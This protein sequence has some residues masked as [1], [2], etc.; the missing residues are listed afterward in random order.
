MGRGRFQLI[1]IVTGLGLVLLLATVGL[2]QGRR[3]GGNAGESLPS[4]E[5]KTAGMRKIDGFLPLYW[6]EKTGRLWMEIARLGQEILHLS[7]IGAGLGS[8]DIGLDRGAGSGSE[9]IKFER[10]GPQ[11]LLIQPNYRFRASSS[12]PEEVRAVTDAFAPSVLWGFPAAAETG[13]RVLVDLTPYV[14]RD[15]EGFTGRLRPGTYR[16][17]SSRSAIY[18]PM[19]MGFP[20]NSEVEATL[21]FVSQGGGG[22]GG[23]RRGGGSFEGV[24]SVAS[25]SEAATVRVHHGFVELPDDD[26]T[27]RLFDS[28]SGFSATTYADYSAPLGDDMVKRFVSRHRLKKKDPRAAVSEA[29]E[30]II[31]Y[32]DPGTPEP[33]RSALLE[34]ARWWNQ[35]FE[36]AGYSE[37]FQVE[38][39]P[40]HISSH[41]IRYNVI[42]WVHRSTRG[43][44]TGGSVRDPRTGEII[45]GI[46]TLGSLRVRQDYMIAEGLLSP[47]RNGDETPPELAAWALARIRQLSAHEVGHTLGLGHNYYDS[48]TGRISVLD[49]PHPLVT[50]KPDGSLD[51]SEVY[52]VGIGEWDKISITYGYTDFAPGTDEK[53]ELAKILNDAWARDIRYM[54]NQDTNVSPRTDQ[55]SNGTN[56]AVELNRMLDVRRNALGRFGVNAIKTGRPMATLEEVLVPLYLHHRYQVEAAASVLGGVHYIYAFRGDNRTPFK[57]ASGSEQRAAMDALLRTLEPS[58]LA[59]PNSILD[60]IPPRPGGY[61]GSRELFPKMTGGMFDTLSPAIVAAS[62]TVFQLLNPARAARIVQQHAIDPALPGLDEILNRL[63]D[64]TRNFTVSD[65]YQREIQRA[66]ERVVIEGLMRLAGN[67]PLTQVRALAAAKLR[68]AKQTFE[69]E[70]SSLTP[71]AAH[72]ALLAEDLERFFQRPGEPVRPLIGPGAPPGAPI[73]QPAMEW[74][75]RTEIGCSQPRLW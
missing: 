2:S 73:G 56:A 18:L 3:G 25:S 34:G 46:V 51:Y 58:E 48:D 63:V 29:V 67:A 53:A 4:I 14:M 40:P 60:L 49:Y 26:Y 55:W 44:S 47:Y 50:L 5:D 36:A 8:N 75:L 24:G 31:Y 70:G 1:R 13:S 11:V 7:G 33:L 69:M 6:E 15:T 45:K 42:N 57:R 64:G 65:P 10:V 52:D 66:V 12:N 74:L 41:D 21:T 17:D 59:L 61:R 32:L 68:A 9:I 30:P 38:I 20:K 23:G 62:H 19:T 43:W 16:F 39:R 22:R 72:Y 37:A 54:S 28:R 71:A 27:P 35:A